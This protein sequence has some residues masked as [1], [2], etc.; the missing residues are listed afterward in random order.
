MP[1]GTWDACAIAEVLVDGVGYYDKPILLELYKSNDL[2]HLVTSIKTMSPDQVNALMLDALLVNGVHCEHSHW[3]KDRP[4]LLRRAAQHYGVS[5]SESTP[6]KAARAPKE[7][8]AGAGGKK[9]KGKLVVA[10][11]AAPDDRGLFDEAEGDRPAG[12]EQS[13]DAGDAG[14][15]DAT[16]GAVD[17]AQE[18][19]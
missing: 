1:R 2:K 7:A 19:A 12:E 18:V 8:T 11:A 17:Q 3:I 4:E 6:S 5:E 13:D 9:R 10:D 15:S 14:G 16:A